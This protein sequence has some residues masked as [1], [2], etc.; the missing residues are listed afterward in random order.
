MVDGK[1][2]E[3]EEDF[4]RDLTIGPVGFRSAKQSEKNISV[5]R[6]PEYGDSDPAGEPL[7]TLRRMRT[8]KYPFVPDDVK[9]SQQ[10][11]GVDLLHNFNPG[12]MLSVGDEVAV[13]RYK[14]P[15]FIKQKFQVEW[16]AGE[17]HNKLMG[18]DNPE[19]FKRAAAASKA[20]MESQN[21]RARPTFNPDLSQIPGSYQ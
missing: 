18:D 8:S 16:I 5:L 9:E 12:Q 20:K 2:E 17:K 6:R 1:I 4:W 7:R 11:F 15:Y 14:S 19:A 13:K 3:F 21:L 10:F